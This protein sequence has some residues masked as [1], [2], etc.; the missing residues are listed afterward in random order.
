MQ[1]ETTL[2]ASLEANDLM[3]ASMVAPSVA[4]GPG[5]TTEMETSAIALD[6]VKL[7]AAINTCMEK[8]TINI[9]RVDAKYAEVVKA[10]EPLKV[11][12]VGAAVKEFEE[13]LK[14]HPKDAK[15]HFTVRAEE[16]EELRRPTNAC[17]PRA[18]GGEYVPRA[19]MLLAFEFVGP[20]CSKFAGT[21]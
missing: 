6:K 11:G 15:V 14:T 13:S 19:I 2:K 3:M 9:S 20:P 4:D 12:A 16:G 5:V 8:I 21:E 1:K 7:A 10:L 17:W 18:V